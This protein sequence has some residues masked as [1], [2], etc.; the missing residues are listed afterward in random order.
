MKRYAVGSSLEYPSVAV[1]STCWNYHH[2]IIYTDC[3]C[4]QAKT[5]RRDTEVKPGT[6][7][8]YHRIPGCLI[9]HGWTNDPFELEASLGLNLHYHYSSFP[10]AFSPVLSYMGV[11][12]SAACLVSEGSP[13][14]PDF[15]LITFDD[16]VFRLDT[17]IELLPLLVWMREQIM[18]LMER[19]GGMH[20]G[21]ESLLEHP[22]LEWVQLR[23]DEWM[24]R[25]THA[26]S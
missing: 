8:T 7:F 18:T 9:P 21:L 14:D 26:T 6:E 24:E 12:A 23:Q 22:E 4:L 10:Q 3:M 19:N 2:P 11:V 20:V 13:L 17:A 15:Y 25:C 5:T 16:Q 1:V